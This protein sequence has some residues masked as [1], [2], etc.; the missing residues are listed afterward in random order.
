MQVTGGRDPYWRMARSDEL[1]REVQRQ[2][3]RPVEPD[4]RRIVDWLGGHIDAHVALVWN[5][6]TVAAA[7]AGF[8]GAVLGTLATGLAR[9]CGGRA[10]VAGL[11]TGGLHLRLEALDPQPEPAGR[12]P[13]VAVPGAGDALSPWPP[14]P[15]LVVAGAAP[16]ARE[17]ARLATDAARSAALLLRLHE[18]AAVHR[19]Y[20]DK[21]RQVRFAVLQA[22]LAGDPDLARRMTSGAIP[23][24]LDAGTLRIY[25]LQCPPAERD[26]LALDLQD[27]SGY[28]DRDLLVQCPAMREHLICLVS[29]DSDDR[30]PADRGAELRRLARDNAGYAL[31]ISAVHALEATSQ[32]YEQARHAL[33]VARNL[34]GAVA[35]YR[36]ESPLARLLPRPDAV[37]WARS[38]L[39]PLAAAPRLTVHI[40]R[41]GLTVSRSGAARF[42]DVSRNTVAAH[43]RR[44]ERLLGL[45]L[46]E[47]VSRA[48]LYLALAL[49]DPPP[50]TAGP[51][52]PAPPF[53]E[54]IRSPP[55]R[56]WAAAF[57]HPLED[58]LRTTARAWIAANAD[59][60]RTAR[61]LGIS[62]NTVR[63]RL[64]TAEVL[65]NRDLLNSG[66]GSYDLVQALA[67]AEGP[68]GRTPM[69]DS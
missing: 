35:T 48:L 55:A 31:G 22:L 2:A 18:A 65:L 1:L 28:H 20:Q 41:V 27:P 49:A 26:R 33:S 43:F 46:G 39:R 30:A 25:L 8:P 51:G 24:L 52:D 4:L 15:V 13:R 45:D 14:R 32:A 16:P 58:T 50:P 60:Q 6:G 44:A 5:T 56:S 29:E 54:L 53:H 34:P 10:G 63:A 40:L 9:L 21:A 17:A 57:L 12:C 64:R 69:K 68:C 47:V 3:A 67:I 19:N 7:S 66:F 62:R 37:E 59:A 36:G 23:E 61:D 11:E 42:L 38:F